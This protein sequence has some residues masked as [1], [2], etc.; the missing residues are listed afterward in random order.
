MGKSDQWWLQDRRYLR[1]DGGEPMTGPLVLP[2][3]PTQD[4][5]ASSKGYVDRMI[6]LVSQT[7]INTQAGIT[8]AAADANAA[9]L[10]AAEAVLRAAADTAEAVARAAADL[11]LLPLGG[12]VMTGVLTLAADPLL[13]MQAATMQYV[14]ALPPA[15]PSTY[16]ALVAPAGGDYTSV[17]TA[18]ATEA[19]GARI[20]VAAGNYV[21]VADV[22]MKDA[23]MLIG[24]HPELTIID[25][26]GGNLMITTAGNNHVVRDLTVT[27]SI[28]ASTLFMNGTEARIDN[29]RILGDA[30]SFDGVTLNG[31]YSVL[32]NCYISG[33]S[34]AGQWSAQIGQNCLAYG[35]TIRSGRSGIECTNA[36]ASIVNNIFSALTTSQILLELNCLAVGNVLMGGQTCIISGHNVVISGNLING[37][38]GITWDA[39][40]DYST[41]NGN[42]FDGSMIN[43]AVGDYHSFIG[44]TF[45]GGLGIVV[46]G[47]DCSVIG[48]TFRGTAFLDFGA[49]AQRNCAVG[50][51]FGA[52]TAAVKLVDAGVANIA[53]DNVGVPVGAEKKFFKMENTSGGALV[54]GDCV[55]LKAVAAGDEIDTTVAIGDDMVFGMLDVNTGNNVEGYVQV[56]GFTNKLKVNG[57]VAIGIG[58]MLCTNNAA[59]IARKAV[60]GNTVFAVALEAYAG[61]DDLGVIDALLICCMKM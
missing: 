10:V 61:A 55:V 29:C 1:R 50:N 24:Q 31:Q 35:N 5:Q 45:D 8:L 21:E 41:I 36:Y 28:D 44:N 6:P 48:N 25:F 20:F 53:C 3:D 12:G 22:A 7:L 2:G 17:A 43:A 4:G 19:V 51:N 60:G 39:N 9:A 34:R 54:A 11:L 38:A 18:C 33:F 27:G 42:Q 49:T 57:T 16:D 30:N 40:V 46:D 58:D 37:A 47:D 52:S 56:E 59:G 14:D 15:A 23:Q 32:S 13:A 26:N